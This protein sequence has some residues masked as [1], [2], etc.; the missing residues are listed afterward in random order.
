MHGARFPTESYTRGCHWIPRTFASIEH[1]DDQWHSSREFTLLSG[2]TVNCVA[3]LKAQ[4]KHDL[5]FGFDD[6]YVESD[7]EGTVL[8]FLNERM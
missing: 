3:T 1:T 6:D 8:S 7:P 4:Q 2:D 5:A